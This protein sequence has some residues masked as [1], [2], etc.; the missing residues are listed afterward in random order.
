MTHKGL[1]VAVVGATGAVG[2][3]MLAILEERKFPISKF[4]P[5]ASEKSVGKKLVANGC[6]G[7]CQILKPGCF[8]GIDLAFFDASDEISKEW[9]PQAL[10]SGAWVVDHSGV[11]RMDKDVPLLVPEIN[12]DVLEKKL[13]SQSSPFVVSGPNCSTVQL[14]L[15]LKPIQKNWGLNRVIVSTYQSTSGAGWEAMEELKTHTSSFLQG[16]NLSPKEFVHPIEFNCIPHIGRFLDTGFT[17]EETKVMEETKKILA[18]PDLLISA[19]AVRVPTL[20]CHSESVYVETRKSAPLASLRDEWKKQ[21]G[22]QVVDDVETNSYPMPIHST[23]KNPVFVGRLRKDPA[24]ENSVSFWVVSDN[25]RKGAAL[26]AV[27]I[28]ELLL[29]NLF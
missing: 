15:A 21:S 27:Q 5:F 7:T 6:E 4:V 29:K 2:R 12:A 10:K 17:S 28:G 26:N 1:K 18:Q 9:T 13:K 16:K 20:S 14:T 19:T 24:H 23:G 25:L 8:D 3:V 22:I 11:F